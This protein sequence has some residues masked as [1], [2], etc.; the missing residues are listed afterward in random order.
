MK[1]LTYIFRSTAVLAGAL[2]L[3]LVSACKKDEV[4]GDLGNLAPA[5]TQAQFTATPTTA[6]PN[7]VEFTSQ[8]TGVIKV[9]WDLGNGSAVV[10]GDKATGSYPLAGTY[11]VKLKI[12]TPG[13][14][15]AESSK[16][17]VIATTN[18]AML[19]D[20]EYALL[21]GGLANPAGKTWL[22][23]KTQPGHLGV[24]P[25]TS[26]GPDWYQAGPNE[27]ASEGM[28]DDE[29]TF[30][31]AAA[32]LKYVY[33]NNGNTFANGA[34][35]AGIGGPGGSAD[36]T[37]SYTPPANMAWS[38]TKSNGKTYININNNGFISYYVGVSTYEIL[39]INANE[40]HL[41]SLEKANAGNAWYLLTFRSLD[42]E[43]P[44]LT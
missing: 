40:M 29:M 19:S 33:A 25:N 14:G 10:E 21:S 26:Q 4:V 23:D 37:L 1:R 2:L 42:I 12:V 20:P 22:I 13:G 44:K 9:A 35:S 15:V 41:R 7:I 18:T 39:S 34:N 8:S 36:V 27:K 17:V 43:S 5:A 28:Y 11:T 32:G 31:M 30:S 16:T 6:N 24:G 3:T 38:L